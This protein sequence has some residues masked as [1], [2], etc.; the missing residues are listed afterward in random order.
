[1]PSMEKPTPELVAL[2]DRSLPKD[3]DVERRQMF[4]CPCAFVNGHMFAGVYERHIIVR[5]PEPERTA[6]LAEPGIGPFAAMG[7]TMREYVALENAVG[8]E[9]AEVARRIARGLEHGRALPPKAPK[10]KKPAK[11]KKAKKAKKAR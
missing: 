1:M 11:T 6:L 2:F 7:R 9:P 10:A 3:P 8:S 4:G 5:S